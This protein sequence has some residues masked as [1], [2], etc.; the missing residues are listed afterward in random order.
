[1]ETIIVEICIGANGEIADFILP[2]H[3]KVSSLVGEL[4]RLVEQAYQE[5]TFGEEPPVL[6][7]LTSGTEISAST[8]L[9]SAG[10]R[11]GYR[12]LLV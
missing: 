1:M 5:I 7:C 8:T 10:V 2:A 9:A 4:V 3:V 6:Y 11:D 12:L